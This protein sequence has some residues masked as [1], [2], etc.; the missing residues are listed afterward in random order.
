VEQLILA[1]SWIA[2]TYAVLSLFLNFHVFIVDPDGTKYSCIASKTLSDRSLP[3]P[4]HCHINVIQDYVCC[5]AFCFSIWQMPAFVQN[6]QYICLFQ[7]PGSE[8]YDLL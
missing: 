1:G 2:S 3:F 6:V 5:D 8:I 7:D 4:E